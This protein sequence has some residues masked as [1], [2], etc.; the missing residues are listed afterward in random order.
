MVYAYSGV[1][2]SNIKEQAAC[3]NIDGSQIMLCEKKLYSKGCVLYGSHLYVLLEK[4]E[5]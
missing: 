4:E 1:V 2:L 3:S 5:L